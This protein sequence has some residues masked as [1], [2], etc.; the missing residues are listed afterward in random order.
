MDN[1]MKNDRREFIKMASLAGLSLPAANAL[2]A[3]CLED[4]K[5][6]NAL[7]GRIEEHQRTHR[8]R[9]NMSGY[10]APAIDTV[11]VGI[12]GLG[13]RGPTYIKTMG[14][15]K[16]VQIKALAE[17]RPDKAGQAE[18]M[19]KSY[20]HNPDVYTGDEDAW[21]ALCKRDDIDLVVVTTHYPAHAKMGMYAMTHGKHTAIAVPVAATIEECWDLVKTAEETK[22]HCMM[23]E[24]C[25]YHTFQMTTLNMARKGFYGELVHGEC[26]YNSSKMRNNF[27]KSMYWNMWWLKEY[28]SKK[29][30]IYPTHGL[31][32]ICQMMDINRGDQFDFLVSMES[33]DFMM[34]DKAA[35]LSEQ[36]SFYDECVGRDYRGNMNCTL[37][38]TKKGRTITLQ[39]DATTPSP[40]TYI[41]GAYGTKGASLNYPSPPRI[42][43]GNHKWASQDVYNKVMTQYKP[44]IIKTFS[45]MASKLG[46]HGGS[47]AYKSWRLI[48]CLRGGFPLDIDVYDSVAWSCI[49]PLSAW[50]VGRNSNSIKIPDFTVGAWENNKRNMDVDLRYF[51]NTVLK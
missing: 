31:G 1:P 21:K 11:R 41:M 33:R 37:I 14:P 5:N 43:T 47:D 34:A 13:N 48:D 30:N 15:L 28:A 3:Q 6:F 9:F 39:H 42:C 29:G 26:A 46:G 44:K 25:S 36:D 45:D 27:S 19:A 49:L 23:L 50:S 51:A 2:Y 4:E 12:I 16:G 35:E 38:K 40:E 22:K 32:P 7:P 17:L 8:Q 24:N 20:G 18:K 10:A